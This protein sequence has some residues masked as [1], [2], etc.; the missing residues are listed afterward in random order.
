MLEAALTLVCSPVS[1][2]LAWVIWPNEPP[3]TMCARAWRGYGTEKW[4]TRWVRVLGV[5]HCAESA[6]WWREARAGRYSGW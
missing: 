2:G 6:L 1:R 3:Q 5:Q 4:A